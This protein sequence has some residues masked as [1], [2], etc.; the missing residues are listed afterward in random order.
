MRSNNNQLIQRIEFA[1]NLRGIASF[2]VLIS[3]LIILFWLHQDTVQKLTGMPFYQG[4]VPA[5]SIFLL[6]NQIINY[7]GF[8]VAL[9]F[10]I[11]GFVIPFALEQQKN[12]QFVINRIF[13]IWPTYIAGLSITLA[14]ML[15]A[16]WYFKTPFIP[17]LKNI[18]YNM[19]LIFDLAG[20]HCIDGVAWTLVIEIKFYLLMMLVPRLLRDKAMSYIIITALIM[21]YTMFLAFY[22]TDV[23]ITFYTKVSKLFMFITF[24]F[25]GTGFYLLYRNKMKPSYFV[26]FTIYLLTLF[27]T[28]GYFNHYLFPDGQ[29][30]KSAY[31]SAFII[32]SLFYVMQD[33]IIFPKIFN[34]LADISYPLY[35]IHS[36]LG[37]IYMHI[38]LSYLPYPNLAL[39]TCVIVVI[40]IAYLLHKI[41]ENPSNQLGKHLGKKYIN[42]IPTSD[43]IMIKVKNELSV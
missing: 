2:F 3:H 10:L 40:C 33:K 13:R 26:L 9:F 21:V 23:G 12:I 25:L 19:L 28:Q 43:L 37:C 16:H 1:N 20:G 27:F 30:V 6:N 38:F 31:L 39:S 5:I 24:M 8:G 15:I 36:I 17:T 34:L 29:G 22:T 14:A 35:V 7:G 42:A 18:I 32:F 41:I 11:S 4:E